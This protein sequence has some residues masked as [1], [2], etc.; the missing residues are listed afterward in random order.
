[1]NIIIPLLEESSG[2]DRYISRYTRYT[3]VKYTNMA[4]SHLKKLEYRNTVSLVSHV[5]RSDSTFTYIAK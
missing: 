3:V 2:R 4:M 5:Q 1:M